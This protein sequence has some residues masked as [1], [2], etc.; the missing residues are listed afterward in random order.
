[1]GECKNNPGFMTGSPNSLGGCRKACG[2]CEVCAPGDG[3]CYRS[4]RSK[5]G[6]ADFDPKVLCS[7]DLLMTSMHPLSIAWLK[8]IGTYS[9]GL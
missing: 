2:V 1:M 6:Y 5:G 9:M 4:N 3:E 8:M 7:W